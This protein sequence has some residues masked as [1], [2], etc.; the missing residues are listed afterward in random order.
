M[1]QN[2]NFGSNPNEA[3]QNNSKID[4]EDMKFVAQRKYRL[5]LDKIAAFPTQRWIFLV[6]MGAVYCLRVYM[7]DG[8]AL[9]TYLLGLFYLNQMLLYLS[10]AEDP[11]DM[12]F[13]DESDFILPMRENDEFKGFQRK[14]YEMELWK[15]LTYATITCF[16]MTFF[17]FFVFPIYWPLLATYFIFMTTFLCRYKIEHMIRYKYIPFEFGKKQYGKTKIR[18]K[19]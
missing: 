9:I 5:F 13:D 6:V 19:K 11:E 18:A 12:E 1:S 7:N 8:Y 10:P 4:F 3:Q 16:F 14:I 15:L 2:Y 17:E